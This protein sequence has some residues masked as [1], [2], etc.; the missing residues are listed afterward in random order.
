[1]TVPEPHRPLAT[2][3]KVL[4][5]RAWSQRTWSDADAELLLIA[6]EQEDERGTLRVRVIRDNLPEERKA[7]R[8]LDRLIVQNLQTL[9]YFRPSDADDRPPANMPVTEFT[10]TN[11]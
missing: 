4:W 10:A 2:Y 6:C 9:G 11:W 3:G 7:L 5:D 1:M 8:E